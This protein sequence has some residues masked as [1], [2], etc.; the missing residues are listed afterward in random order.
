MYIGDMFC[1]GSSTDFV[2]VNG[3]VGCMGVFISCGTTFY[4]I[5]MPE[6]DKLQ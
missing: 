1:Y 6:L 2:G 3:I 4:A 5:H